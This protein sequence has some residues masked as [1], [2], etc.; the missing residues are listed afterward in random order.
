MCQLLPVMI[1]DER[2]TTDCSTFTCSRICYIN[3]TS[4]KYIKERYTNTHTH[5]NRQTDTQIDIQTYTFTDRRTLTRT[6]RQTGTHTHSQIQTDT[7]VCGHSHTR[8][9]VCIHTR[10]YTHVVVSLKKLSWRLVCQYKKLPKTTAIYSP[11][12]VVVHG[13]CWPMICYC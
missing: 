9:H 8:T 5:T 11:M 3:S 2:S 6:Q 1:S 4:G 7:Q 10:T 12:L 13:G